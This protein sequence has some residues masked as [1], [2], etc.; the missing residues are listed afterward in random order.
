MVTQIPDPQEVAALRGLVDGFIQERLQLSLKRIEKL[1][2]DDA[3]KQVQRA[4]E[5]QRHNRSTWLS[6]SAKAVSNNQFSTHTIKGFHP[7]AHG[8]NLYVNT[9]ISSDPNLLG[10]HTLQGQQIDDVTGTSGGF[11]AADFLKIEHKGENLLVRLMQKDGA[12]LAAL[13]DDPDRALELA[14]SFVNIVKIKGGNASHSFAKQV[15]FPIGDDG[16]HLLSP[17]YPASLAH[18]FY[19]RLQQDRFSDAS[20][21]A[22]NAEYHEQEYPHG[23]CD[24]PGIAV[25]KMGGSRPQNIS[26]L[27]GKR[28][29]NNYLLA[30]VPPAWKDQ[31][32]KPPLRVLSVFEKRGAI[33]SDLAVKR[34]TRDLKDFLS[35]VADVDNNM[36]I[37]EK[38]ASLVSAIIDH[39]LDT[40]TELQCLNGGWSADPACKLSWAQKQWLDCQALKE[41]QNAYQAQLP[42]TNDSQATLAEPVA[43]HW[44]EIVAEDFARW[45]NATLIESDK[46]HMGNY[47]FI[48]FKH[49]FLEALP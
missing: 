18:A 8:T 6:S 38:R 34:S 47:E 41:A 20:I 43:S 2:I 44:R 35:S 21:A 9:F 33:G 30:S 11:A 25:C 10:T 23:Y 36:R 45:L 46:L 16:Y 42:A 13:S 37:S 3:L 22:R 5:K 1:K 26:Q 29:G 7:S 12:T 15:Y 32:I 27:N 19:L 28:N 49:M 17:L 24:Y 4:A 14:L 31:G 39:V 48:R 40:A